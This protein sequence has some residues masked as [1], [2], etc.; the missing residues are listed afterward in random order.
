MLKYLRRQGVGCAGTVRTTKITTKETFEDAARVEL[1]AEDVSVKGRAR[2][3]VAKERF[4]S[5]LMR[6]KTQFTKH[7]EWGEIRWDLSK[8]GEVLQAAWRDNQVVLFASTVAEP[9]QVIMKLRRRSKMSQ[10]NKGIFEKA[11]GN[12]PVRLLGIL[13][14][15]DDYNYHKTKRPLLY[16]LLDLTLNNAY[17][18]SLYSDAAAAKRSGHKRF[19]Y[20]LIEQLFDRGTRLCNAG[21]KRKRSDDVVV[22]E[23]SSHRSANLYKQAKTCVLCAERGRRQHKSQPPRVALG[24][25]QGNLQFP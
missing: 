8:S 10:N 1:Q 2:Q 14:M 24:H 12:E 23:E 19:L 18:L 25:V 6:L 9:I 16:F 11:F 3:K 4:S 7:M 13:Q 22:A 17:R 20:D 15:I 5:S 21:A